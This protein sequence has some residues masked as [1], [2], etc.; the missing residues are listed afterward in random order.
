MDSLVWSQHAVLVYCFY[1]TPSFVSN[2]WLFP[3][4]LQGAE[5]RGFVLRS[6]DEIFVLLEDMGLNLQ[7]MMASR[8][9]RPFLDQVIMSPICSV[10]LSRCFFSLTFAF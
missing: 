4:D 3:N 7:S 10:H 5:D 8:Y 6:T 2:T 9:V 1:A